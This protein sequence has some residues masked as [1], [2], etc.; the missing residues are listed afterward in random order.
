[1][2]SPLAHLINANLLSNYIICYT[3]PKLMNLALH[4]R[5]IQL[6]CV[7]ILRVPYACLGYIPQL[8]LA[9]VSPLPTRWN[10]LLTSPMTKWVAPSYR[11]FQ[12][13]WDRSPCCLNYNQEF[14]GERG[15]MRGISHQHSTSSTLLAQQE[16]HSSN[17]FLFVV[18]MQCKTMRVIFE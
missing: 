7:S 12:T 9:F 13:T 2:Q 17:F 3:W 15:L 18:L 4:R 1:M 6:L 8:S 14:S 10:M 11:S 5:C 16:L